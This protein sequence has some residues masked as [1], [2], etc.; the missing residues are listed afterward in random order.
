[1]QVPTALLC[2]TLNFVAFPYRSNDYEDAPLPPPKKKKKIKPPTSLNSSINDAE[3]TDDNS[4]ASGSSAQEVEIGNVSL[5]VTV[6]V[7]IK[8]AASI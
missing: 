7:P 8:D 2:I 3:N 1:M 6:P 5:L 4:G